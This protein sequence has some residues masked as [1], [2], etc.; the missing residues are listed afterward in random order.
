[1]LR[2]LV[3]PLLIEFAV[4][5]WQTGKGQATTRQTQATTSWRSSR[6]TRRPRRRWP[7]RPTPEGGALH[8][9]RTRQAASRRAWISRSRRAAPWA[10][11]RRLRTC[12]YIVEHTIRF[13]RQTERGRARKLTDIECFEHRAFSEAV[14]DATNRL[15]VVA[16]GPHFLA[17]AFDVSIDGSSRD[18]GVDAP[19][20]VE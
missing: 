5:E 17:Q 15:D 9:C 20:L 1:V 12:D 8:F 14:A 10:A 4:P 18:L 3:L 13:V 6:C 7:G 2:P 19:H 11:C 16:S